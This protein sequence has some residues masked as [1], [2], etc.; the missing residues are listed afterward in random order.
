MTV[1]KVAHV[2]L[3]SFGYLDIEVAPVGTRA[4]NWAAC[5]AHKHVHHVRTCTHVHALRAHIAASVR[6]HKATSR[7]QVLMHFLAHHTCHVILIEMIGKKMD[8]KAVR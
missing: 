2:A 1:S 7:H 4:C 8:I 6:S 5:R 3:E